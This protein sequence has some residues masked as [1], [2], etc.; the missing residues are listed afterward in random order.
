MYATQ[1][2]VRRGSALLL[3]HCSALSQL[4]D[5]RPG[6]F[7]RLEQQVGGDFARFLVS[8]L[9]APREAPRIA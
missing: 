2:S 1:N 7:E 9:L 3:A 6:A 8:A 5:A 4:D